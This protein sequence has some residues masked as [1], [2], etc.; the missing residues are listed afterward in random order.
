M[1]SK[2]PIVDPAYQ[3]LGVP[4]DFNIDLTLQFENPLPQGLL[5][6]WE[7]RR[8]GNRLPARADFDME[9]LRPY[10]GWICLHRVHDD[11]KDM[12]LSLV[13]SRVVESAGRDATGQALSEVMPAEVAK[14]AMQV[15]EHPRPLRLW[16]SADWRD[17]E[18]MQ[19]EELILP[20]A[21]DG[22]M[23]D[24]LMILAYFYR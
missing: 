14:I 8:D 12:T 17:R 19:H 20:L 15:L 3:D 4:P 6:E 22:V 16:G 7:A 24:Q 13:G 23:V 11:R 5:A 9:C 21:N 2:W 10:L 18:Y 1:Q